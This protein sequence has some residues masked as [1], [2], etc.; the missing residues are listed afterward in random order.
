MYVV[1]ALCNVVYATGPA[2]RSSVTVENALGG[3]LGAGALL[4]A[5]GFTVARRIL[6]AWTLCALC[7][8]Y[9]ASAVFVAPTTARHAPDRSAGLDV[10]LPQDQRRRDRAGHH[11]QRPDN[12]HGSDLRQRPL[13]RSQHHHATPWVT[14]SG[15]RTV[16]SESLFLN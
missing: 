3:A 9:I 4:V 5:A 11:L 15:D 1:F 16:G 14:N 8:P 10:R 7:L 13:V 6:G 12:D 2:G